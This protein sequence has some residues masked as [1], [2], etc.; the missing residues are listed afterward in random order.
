MN[1]P[2]PLIAVV[3]ATGLQGGSAA[4]ALLQRGIRVRAL[5]RDPHSARAAAL[6]GRGVELMSGD[7]S[8]PE[9]LD[10]LFTGADAAFAMSTMNE[11]G[12]T[13]GETAAGLAIAD[14]AARTGLPHL[15][16]GS[17]GGAER[18]TGIP[19]SEGKRRVEEHIR[20]LGLHATLLRP[21]FLMENF[22]RVG[23]AVDERGLTVSLPL[24]DGVP[25]QMVAVRDVGQAAAA[26]LLGGTEAEGSAVE[27]G[28]DRRTGSQIAAAFGEAANLPARYEELP[29]ETVQGDTAAM[30][31]WLAQ[32]PA[33]QAD[34]DATRALVD[35]SGGPLDLAAWIR[36]VGWKAG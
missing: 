8:R 33:Y 6:A 7:L 26:I 1:N 24:P 29:V 2:A 23:V 16:Y 35:G 36:A 21:V 11:P 34:F 9:N 32:T 14:A 31:L 10:A 19:P 27:I 20:A 5:V 13:A 3:G 4:D 18:H 17:V 15:L 12:G 30:F 22:L 25:L 28:G